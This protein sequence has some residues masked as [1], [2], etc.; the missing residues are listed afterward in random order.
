V[1]GAACH[2]LALINDI[3]ELS[4]IEA[5]PDQMRLRQAL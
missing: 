2:Q 1:L 3:L 5:G 4:K